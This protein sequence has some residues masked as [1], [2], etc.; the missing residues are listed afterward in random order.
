MDEGQ[1]SIARSGLTKEQTRDTLE[2][3]H[4]NVW[5]RAIFDA[6]S[7]GT[8]FMFVAFA[9][10]LGIAKERIAVITVMVNSACI[11]QIVS[12]GLTRR[13]RDKKRFV[14]S[15]ALTEPVVMILAVLCVRFLPQEI[16][17]MALAAAAFAGAGALHLTRPVV[18]EWIA[19]SIPAG[20]RGRYLGRRSQLMSIS[21]VVAT[22]AL[23]YIGEQIDPKNA[24]GFAMVVAAGGVF[25]FLAVLPLRHASL[26]MLSAQSAVDWADLPQV[27]HHK[28]YRRFLAASLL[29]TCPF[30]FSVPFY[31]VFNLEV[32]HLSKRAIAYQLVLYVVTKVAVV[33]LIGR[34]LIRWRPMRVLMGAAVVYAA[35]FFCYPAAAA[36]GSWAIS[37]AW[38]L[39]GAGDGAWGV[40]WSSAMYAVV[41][42]TRSRP[43]YFAVTNL[44]LLGG[45]ALGALVAMVIL[46]RIK[47]CELEIGPYVLGQF[48]LFYLGC[49]LLMIPC[50]FAARM[51][52][53]RRELMR[54][55]GQA[56]EGEAAGG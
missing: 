3:F 36:C 2:S 20:L 45:Q 43:A 49:G 11:L 21:T 6:T 26:P 55:S 9:L 33:P 15:L 17:L 54:R 53:G 14:M 46:E 16:R 27:L 12:I 56:L 32:L 42:K 30:F 25:G 44:F 37:L 39:A 18:D 5:L 19:S 29:L 10:A 13:V 23:G 41:P 47:D 50:A 35:F 51:F 28:P 38:I 1:N 4:W 7:G 40:A 31:Q 34:R 24:A 8:T 48:H 22:L 52:V